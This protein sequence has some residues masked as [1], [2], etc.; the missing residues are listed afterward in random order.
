MIMEE[1]GANS[2]FM[3]AGTLRWSNPPEHN[4]KSY[5]API[6]LFPVE[7]T[8]DGDCIRGTG[9]EPVVNLTLLEMLRQKFGISIPGLDP[10]PRKDGRIDV[11]LVLNTIRRAVMDRKDWDVDPLVFIG[12]FNFNKFVMWN[13]IHTHSEMLDESPVIR[14]LMEGKLDPKVICDSDAEGK[15]IDAMCPPS[16]ILLPIKAD[17]SQMKAIR[18]AVDGKSFIVHG[19]AGTG[20]SQTITN[21]IANA[22]Y[23]GKRVLFVSEKKAALEVV[24]K[25]LASIGLD[26]FCLELHSNRDQDESPQEVG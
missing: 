10:L 15:D 5:L 8:R 1:C 23:R 12:T 19:P 14:S 7:F 21:I 2:L 22:L 18:D 17:S 6:L 20:K 11:Q 24:Q 13:D 26:P 9:E 3:T 25:R 4:G 16:D